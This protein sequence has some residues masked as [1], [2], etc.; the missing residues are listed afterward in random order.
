MS[1][2]RKKPLSEIE[3]E[4]QRQ[5]EQPAQK[6][7]R[8][9]ILKA[10][11]RR[12]EARDDADGNVRILRKHAEFAEARAFGLGQ[13]VEAD[14]DRARDRLVAVALVARIEH[15]E[16]LGVEPLVRAGD[17]DGQRLVRLHDAVAQ[18]AVDDL[19]QL[20]PFAEPRGEVREAAR[21]RAT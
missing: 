12:P 16:A 14:A 8:L 7:F 21:A 5:I 15:A 1:C 6:V 4:Q 10:A 17:R 9:E 19:E 11:R 13:K 18:E 20:R 2:S 3:I